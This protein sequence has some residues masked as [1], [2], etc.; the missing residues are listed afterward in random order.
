MTKSDY[1]STLNFMYNTLHN[2]MMQSNEIFYDVR[3]DAECVAV[4]KPIINE[5][6]TTLASA[7]ALIRLNLGVTSKYKDYYTMLANN[8]SIYTETIVIHVENYVDNLTAFMIDESVGKVIDEYINSFNKFKDNFDL[9]LTPYISYETS[10]MLNMIRN[11][12][13]NIIDDDEELLGSV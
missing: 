13:N 8:V 1:V 7:M 5:I 10:E 12:R 6:N 4:C 9:L 11:A 2:F 3:F